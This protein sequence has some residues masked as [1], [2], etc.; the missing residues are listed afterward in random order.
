MKRKMPSKLMTLLIS[1]VLLCSF[2]LIGHAEDEGGVM[3]GWEAWGEYDDENYETVYKRSSEVIRLTVNTEFNGYNAGEEPELSY[4]WYYKLY[5]NQK[6]EPVY[7]KM[8]GETGSTCSVTDARVYCCK[9]SDSESDPSEVEFRVVQINKGC[10]AGTPMVTADEETGGYR[11]IP[12]DGDVIAVKTN[13]GTK[14]YIYHGNGEPYNGDPYL[15]QFTSED[16]DEV[17]AEY[18]GY[19]EEEAIL[20]LDVQHG[21][22]DYCYEV[23]LQLNANKASGHNYG[24]WVTTTAPTC[25]YEGVKENTCSICGDKITETI[26]ALGHD[27]SDWETTK[28]ATEVAAGIQTRTC[29]RCGEKETQE[30]AQLKPSLKVVTILKPKAAKKSAAIKWKKVSKKNLKKIKKIEIQYSTDKNFNKN[31]KSKYA[32]ATKTS[33]KIKKLKSK[34]KYYVRI[35]AYTKSGGQVHV[36]KWSAKKSF[37]VK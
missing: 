12:C 25:L 27:Y 32:K 22:W 8:N 7:V 2:T 33:Y 36:S 11:F 5:D 6:N 26:P 4:Q 18:D 13:S 10:Y 17:V 31:V 3:P 35:R 14:K 28:P 9:V 34:K 30:I 37:R 15:Y 23:F 19:S 20:S 1:L 29:S 21:Q 16:G 24:N